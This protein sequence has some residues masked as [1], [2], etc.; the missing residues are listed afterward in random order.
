ML[1]IPLLIQP[2]SLSTQLTGLRGCILAYTN[3]SDNSDYSSL[4]NIIFDFKAPETR[5]Q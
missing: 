4:A 1:A 5:G 2:K 3:E